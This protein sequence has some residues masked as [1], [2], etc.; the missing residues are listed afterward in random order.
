MAG[1]GG[2][3]TLQSIEVSSGPAQKVYGQGQEMSRSGL[4][5]TGHFK[6]DSRE[7]TNEV[8]VSGYN[9]DRPGEQTVTVTMGAQS[10]VFTVTVVPVDKV[11]ITQP[12]SATVFMQGDDFN[13]AGLGALAEFEGG[14]VP[15]ETLAPGRLAFSGYDKNRAG[16]QTVTADYY[17]RRVSFEV[18]VAALSRITVA[19]PP[20]KT[21][22]FTG[23]D[24]DLAGIVVM[25]TWEGAGERP[26][27][28]TKENLSSF[29]QNRAGRQ[30][31]VVS[32]QGKTVTF[33]VTFTAMQSVAVSRPPEKLN[34]ENGE[35]LDLSG[36]TVQ[37]TRTGATSIEMVDNERLKISGYDRFQ[38]GNQTVTLTIGGR[39]AT[40]RVTVAP[41][42]FVGVWRGA[43]LRTS[44][45]KTFRRAAL[46]TMQEDSWTIL[47]E[48]SADFG[49]PQEEYGGTY[50]RDNNKGRSVELQLTNSGRDRR[51]P[52]TGAY[53]S[54]ENGSSLQITGGAF[55]GEWSGF[56]R[57][58]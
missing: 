15:A 43:L 47:L 52:P 21:D 25:G 20:D 31:V 30:D 39:S 55:N 1:L 6:K 10:A 28:V 53:I 37:G 16:T 41:N 57:A 38:G 23:E 7:I 49:A 40:F 48:E 32:Y 22:Y 51:T 33:P 11:T 14:A 2:C 4:V 46:L 34:Y 9:K 27:G 54:S 42:P 26:V 8:A 19:S 36:L 13:P 50:T 24:L 3:N 44:A 12:P 45:G 18:R 5:V 58:Q 56:G 17:G 29:D 35:E